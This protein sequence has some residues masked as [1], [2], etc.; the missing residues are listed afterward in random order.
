MKITIILCTHN[1]CEILA[2]AL[3]S[4]AALRLPP[5]VEWEV[6]VVNNNS[7]DRTR[8][9]VENFC[10]RDPVHFR[11][12]FEPQQGKSYALNAGIREAQ[13]DVLAFMDD[14][15]TVEPT[16]LI[17]LTTPLLS[18]EWAGS[19]GRI[20]PE[21]SFVPPPW[22]PREGRYSLAPL[23]MFDCGP[24]AGELSEPPFGTNMAFR[25]EMFEKYGGFRTD[26]GP[27]PGAEIRSEDTEFGRRLLTAGE[28]LRY[29][30]SAVVYHSV[31][32][33]RLHKKYF[34]AWWFDKARA[35]IREFPT[36]PGAK[37]C[38]AGIPLYWFR[39]L[40]VWTLR[41]MVA[42]K[43]HRRFSNKVKVWSVLG[44]MLEYHNSRGQALG[45]SG[46]V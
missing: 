17:N 41:W 38:I 36:P 21:R 32:Q 33:N 14:D 39:R 7:S 24:D 42:I 5:S 20:L 6:L 31:S 10:H 25:K 23:V 12:L 16:W 13:G 22:L 8:E 29:E 15:V 44:S 9:V 45:G 3:E 1:R 11:Y 27:R 19:G 43:P 26:L 30:P 28:R 18:G 40:A 46:G 2:K 34:L 37:W 4:A 35:D